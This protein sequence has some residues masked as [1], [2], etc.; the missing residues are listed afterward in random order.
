MHTPPSCFVRAMHER[1]WFRKMCSTTHDTPMPDRCHVICY[2]CTAGQKWA[3]FRYVVGLF[4]PNNG[5]CMVV[6]IE[7]RRSLADLRQISG[8]SLADLRQISLGPH[9]LVLHLSHAM[10]F[11]TSHRHQLSPH[12]AFCSFVVSGRFWLEQNSSFLLQSLSF[13]LQN[14]SFLMQNPS[15][16]ITFSFT[17]CPLQVPVE[18][19][20]LDTT[21]A[22]SRS[23]VF[24]IKLFMVGTSTIYIHW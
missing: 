19:P 7:T 11:H 22:I 8:R 4:W 16:S 21:Q 23:M 12:R 18:T 10:I 3:Y 20:Q 15:L 13:L 24:K 17:E 2:A 1:R 14:P 9:E 6:H 5:T